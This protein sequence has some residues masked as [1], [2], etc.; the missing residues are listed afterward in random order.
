MDG[1]QGVQQLVQVHRFADVAIH[2][3]VEAGLLVFAHGGRGHGKDDRL[4]YGWEGAANHACRF[5]TI[6]LRH[7][8]V[9][10]DQIVWL[11]LQRF[12]D[13]LPVGGN[14][15][16]VAQATQDLQGYLLVDDIVFCEQDVQRMLAGKGAV[17]ARGVAG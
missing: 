14:V 8:Y 16:L 5:Q 4:L 9:H 12:D 17:E 3:C 11:A 1:F 10:Q 6:H 2:A 15:G 7:L 13:L